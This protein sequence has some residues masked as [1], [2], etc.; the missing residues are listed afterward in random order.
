MC[1]LR[2]VVVNMHNKGF[3]LIEIIV[4]V[5]LFTVV[6]MLTVGSLFILTSAEKRVASVQANQDNIRFT[7]ELM[8][9]EIRTGDGAFYSISPGC[10]PS[11]FSFELPTGEVVEYT[12]DSG[13]IFRQVNSGSPYAITGSEVSIEILSFDLKAA[14][15]YGDDIQPHVTIALKGVAQKNTPNAT[16]LNVQTSIT[17][18][19][20]N[21]Y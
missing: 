21:V 15:P 7:M 11:C 14:D 17:P 5:G 6:A 19:L 18:L 9:R 20:I 2:M 16:T 10:R 13:R 3:S 12:L 4:A 1:L 8:S